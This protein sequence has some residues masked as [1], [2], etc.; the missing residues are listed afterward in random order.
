[1]RMNR[2]AFLKRTRQLT[3]LG[4][5]AGVYTWKV[6]P[7]W[8]E[9][10]HRD[11]PIRNLPAHLAGKTLLQISDIHVG[12]RFDYQFI[13]DAFNQATSYQPDIVVYTGD[14]VSYESPEQFTQLREVMAHAVTRQAWNGWYPGQP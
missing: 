3:G 11:L 14:Y 4:L 6:E 2:R 12:N 13:I 5:L 8:L 7:F 10:V 9:F 1:M